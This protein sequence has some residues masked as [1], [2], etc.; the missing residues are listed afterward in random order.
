M[1][2]EIPAHKFL[3]R[4]WASEEPPFTLDADIQT[5]PFIATQRH[6]P[7]QDRLHAPIAVIQQHD[8]QGSPFDHQLYLSGDQV[9]IRFSCLFFYLF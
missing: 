5:I 3:L 2:S 7:T 8:A 1:G 4:Y 9:C 6:S